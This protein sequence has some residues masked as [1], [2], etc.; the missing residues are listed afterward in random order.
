[1]AMIRCVNSTEIF[2]LKNL[3]YLL[4]VSFLCM[5]MHVCI[6]CTV[7]MVWFCSPSGLDVWTSP[8]HLFCSLSFTMVMNRLLNI[9]TSSWDLVGRC[10]SPAR[11]YCRPT[12]RGS[13]L[14]RS[15]Y[16]TDRWLWRLWS[17][18][19][20]GFFSSF[21]STLRVWFPLSYKK[22]MIPLHSL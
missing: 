11:F 5:P 7:C 9:L 16:T 4:L 20:K 13:S 8:T 6:T 3:D 21:C 15:A 22:G 19:S 10:V 17:S 14:V 1:M 2:N 12:I 18:P